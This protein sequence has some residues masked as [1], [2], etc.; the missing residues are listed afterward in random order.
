MSRRDEALREL[1]L[2]R[3]WVLTSH[4][5][6][7]NVGDYGARKL[8]KA[9]RTNKSLSKLSLGTSALFSDVIEWDNISDQGARC[10]ADALVS[11][12][13]TFQLDIRTLLCAISLAD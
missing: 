13:G 8:A 4:I 9:L 5:G 12:A 6:E 7:N 2:G 3:V 10:L 1:D 11:R